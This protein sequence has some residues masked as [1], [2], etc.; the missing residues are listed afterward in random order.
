MSIMI[1]KEA[2]AGHLTF[3]YL[4]YPYIFTA[5]IV[6][7]SS[8]RIEPF[9]L[10]SSGKMAFSISEKLISPQTPHPWIQLKKQKRKKNVYQTRGK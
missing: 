3:Q 7:F 8:R 5:Y 1:H 6:L 10:T 2:V 9:L 4:S